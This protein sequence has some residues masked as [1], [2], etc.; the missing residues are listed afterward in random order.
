MSKKL[1]FISSFL[2]GL[3][4]AQSFNISLLGGLAGTATI[5]QFQRLLLLD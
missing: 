4:T 5:K 2:P 1:L 3:C